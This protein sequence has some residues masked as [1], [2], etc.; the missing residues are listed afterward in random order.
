MSTFPVDPP[1]TPAASAPEDAGAANRRELSQEEIATLPLQALLV[2]AGHITLDQLADALRENVAT[3]RSV[4][5]IA[6]SRGWL[7]AA[8]LDALRAAK[9]NYAPGAPAPV[10]QPPA[11]PAARTGRRGVCTAPSSACRRSAG[12]TNACLRGTCAARPGRAGTSPGTCSRTGAGRAGPRPRPRRPRPC[13]APAPV[14]EAPTE[15]A[16]ARSRHVGRRVP[17]PRGRRAHLGGPLRQPRRG[18]AACAEPDRVAR[19]AG[20]R[21]LASLR[22]PARPPR[23][24]RQRRSVAARRTLNLTRGTRRLARASPL[25]GIRGYAE[26]A[27]LFLRARRC[28]APRILRRKDSSSERYSD[29]RCG[30]PAPNGFGRFHRTAPEPSGRPSLRGGPGPGTRARRRPRSSGR[31]GRAGPAARA[32]RRTAG[33]GAPAARPGS[34]RR[35]R[36]RPPRKTSP[37][38]CS[39][40]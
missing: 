21:C 12:R 32:T 28:P 39:S 34:T 27:M 18:R 31:A 24:C 11:A 16:S 19:S 35:L 38:R 5:D 36:R 8:Q 14:V 1:V 17:E 23:R 9:Q 26:M 37:L 10:A 22:R 20:A 6:L 33:G 15:R 4:E 7:S 29:G 30:V 13:P 2:R 40:T 25:R 3:G